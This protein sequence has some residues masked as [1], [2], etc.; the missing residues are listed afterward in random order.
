LALEYDVAI[1]LRCLMREVGVLCGLPCLL[2]SLGGM[3]DWLDCRAKVVCCVMRSVDSG[4]M[5]AGVMD[6]FL[7]LSMGFSFY[8]SRGPS[9]D[10]FISIS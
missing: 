4:R 3:R 5:R 10:E 1:D 6:V 9:S 2:V 7:C 8:A